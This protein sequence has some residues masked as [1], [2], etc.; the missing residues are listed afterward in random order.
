MRKML[1]SN[2]TACILVL[3]LLTASACS[4]GYELP[5]MPDGVQ[6][7]SLLGDTLYT[8][9]LDPQLS[10]EYGDSVQTALQEYRRDPENAESLIWLGRRAAYL[11]EYREAIETFTEGIFKHPD[12]PRMY[13]HRGH[14]YLTLRM[15]DRAIADFESAAELMRNMEDR[16]EPDG[17][18]NDQNQPT[19]TLKSNVWYHKGLAHYVQAEYPAAI[20]AYENALELDLTQDMRIATLY[21]YYMAL[22]R[23]GQVEKAGRAISEISED[24]EVIENEAYLNLLLVFNGVFRAERLMET[25]EDALQNATLGYGIGNW[26]YMNGREERAIDIWEQ[27]YD[28]GNWPAFGYIAAEAEL[29]RMRD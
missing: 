7:V 23:D 25:T 15:F 8:P 2:K 16:V 9:E 5:E 6:T 24:I 14:R 11:G 20:D 17:L 4:S 19:S 29:A 27:V 12:D 22:R 13:R 1:I 3:T 18:P 26:H 10:E 28:E 21:W